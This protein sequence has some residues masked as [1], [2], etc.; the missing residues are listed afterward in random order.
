MWEKPD[1]EKLLP[2]FM[3]NAMGFC[4]ALAVFFGLPAITTCLLMRLHHLRYTL[5]PLWYMHTLDTIFTKLNVF[6]LIHLVP[7]IVVRYFFK[8]RLKVSEALIMAFL[9]S[10][11]AVLL[12]YP[13]KSIVNPRMLKNIAVF[14]VPPPLLMAFFILRIHKLRTWGS[15]VIMFYIGILCGTIF[16]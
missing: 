6:Y 3:Q 9:L 7:A 13:G 10:V 1:S 11:L 2:D 15:I 16:I 12:I 5:F 4:A 8:T 14:T